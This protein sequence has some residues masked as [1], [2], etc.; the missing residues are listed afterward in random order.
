MTQRTFGIFDVDT[1]QTRNTGGWTY[2][3][4]TQPYRD[5]IKGLLAAARLHHVPTIAT[6]CVGGHMRD[7][8]PFSMVHPDTLF[9]P[10]LGGDGTWW[11]RVDTFDS[12]FVEKKPRRSR[13]GIT[14][15]DD[16]WQIFRN[17]PNAARL[18]DRLDLDEWVVFGN[19]MD[20]CGD[21]VVTHFLEQGRTVRYIPELMIPGAACI[22]CEPKF[23]KQHVYDRWHAHGV[24]PISLADVLARTA[25]D[26]TA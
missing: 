21:L 6:T 18:I 15:G 11:S 25:L 23:F 22:G 19:A 16:S 17:N 13:Q 14:P 3:A 10:M 8:H 1:R 12:F 4:R 24:E 2:M 7:E 20:I 26:L 5:D 9:V